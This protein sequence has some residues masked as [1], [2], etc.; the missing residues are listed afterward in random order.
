MGFMSLFLSVSI[1]AEL[2]KSYKLEVATVSVTT[3]ACY[4]IV[5]A[6]IDLAT[7]TL[8]TGNF[9]AG[10][11]FSVFLVAIIVAEVMRLC[12]DH[13]IGIKMPKEVPEN[14]SASFSALIPMAILL[15]GFWL[16]SIVFGFKINDILT[17]IISP[18]LAV[19]DTWYAV[20][21]AALIT[22][23]LWFVGIQGGSFTN[24]G[25]LYP[26]L[27]ANLAAN[28]EAF[29]S[30]NPMEHIYTEPF[31]YNWIMIG[32]VG[33]TLP[34]VLFYWN[35]K[36]ARLR[37]VA[38]LEIAPGLFNINEPIMFGVPI[39][40]NPIMLIPFI[41]ISLFGGLYGYIITK[42]GLIS[43]TCVQTP[44]SIPPLIGPYL[45]TGGDWRAVV[46]QIILI[47][48]T[49]MMWYP[50]AKLWEKKCIEEEKGQAAQ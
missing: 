8:S 48:L 12:R 30:G 27:L 7:G 9:G 21:I 34:L 47:I 6:P 17:V 5:V 1:A 15:V 3:L 39:V 22:C 36:S 44:W 19:S 33:C 28:A 42:I 50:F 38:R 49:G 35:S 43:S 16:I 45:S 18:L 29:A 14:I 25:V 40:L 4:L 23:L 20:C 26:F 31:V 37:E 32:G 13:N 46:A 24:Q 41:G 10:G 11:L 2:A